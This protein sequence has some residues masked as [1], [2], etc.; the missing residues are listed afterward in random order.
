MSNETIDEDL[1]KTK[2][3]LFEKGFRFHMTPDGPLQPKPWYAYKDS[4]IR[5]RVCECNKRPKIQ[6]CVDP[7]LSVYEA[8]EQP[9]FKISIR[10]EANGVWWNLEA[11]TLTARDVVERYE[12]IERSLVSAWNALTQTVHP[13]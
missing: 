7:W 3:F 10:G 5:A 4:V 2:A 11:Y 13:A 1:A 12:D 8:G 6:I 9:T